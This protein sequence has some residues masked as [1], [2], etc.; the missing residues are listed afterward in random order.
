MK[1]YNINEAYP[2]NCVNPCGPVHGDYLI[3]LAGNRKSIAGH[4][5]NAWPCAVTCFDGFP[6]IFMALRPAPQL[7]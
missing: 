5:T 7:L 2:S 3:V 6:I 4:I 1:T